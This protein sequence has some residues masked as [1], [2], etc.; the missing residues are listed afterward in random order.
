MAILPKSRRE[1]NPMNEYQMTV[2]A[3]LMKPYLLLWSLGYD[4]SSI[5]EIL[6][7]IAIYET[8]EGCPEF[9]NEAEQSLVEDTLPYASVE[10]WVQYEHVRFRT[11]S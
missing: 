2:P 4:L 3:T 10:K 1:V 7:H 11:A 6:S 9:R 8:T 5:G